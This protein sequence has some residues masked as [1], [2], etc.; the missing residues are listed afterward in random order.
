MKSGPQWVSKKGFFGETVVPGP[1]LGLS[2]FI[3]ESIKPCDMSRVYIT[4]FSAISCLCVEAIF[5]HW[6]GKLK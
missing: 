5:C 2:V 6:A 3:S 1:T 4:Y